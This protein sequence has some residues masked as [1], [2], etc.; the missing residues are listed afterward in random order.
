MLKKLFIFPIR[1]YQIF[2][3]PLLGLKKCRFHPTCSQYM[4]EAIEEW[5]VLKG[6][7][8]GI[9]RISKCHPWGGMGNDPVPKKN[10]PQP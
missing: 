10:S 6:M 3:S 9:K 5:G 4:I 8:L 2:L 7:S 1:M